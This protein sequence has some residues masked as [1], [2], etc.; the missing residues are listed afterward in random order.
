MPA[1]PLFPKCTELGGRG[2]EEHEPVRA[3]LVPLPLG[4]SA[5]EI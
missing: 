1:G 2:E 3:E 4:K 5:E